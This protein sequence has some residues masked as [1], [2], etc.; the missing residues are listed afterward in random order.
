MNFFNR[1]GF[2]LIGV[3]LGVGVIFISL[4]ESNRS[5]TFNY[6]PNNRVKNYLLSNQIFISDRALCQFHCHDLDTAS[7]K[8]EISTSNVDFQRSQIRGVD[9]NTYYLSSDKQDL[10]FKTFSDSIILIGVLSDSK[11]CSSCD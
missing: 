10:V 1:F 4:K 11:D 8:Q 7:L 6:F 5:F 9:I 2:F 3:I